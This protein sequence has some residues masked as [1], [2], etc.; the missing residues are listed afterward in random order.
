MSR[1][2]LHAACAAVLVAGSPLLANTI[3]I[4][5]NPI[6]G[7]SGVAGTDYYVYKVVGSNLTRDDAAP[8]STILQGSA[9]VAGNANPQG[10]V[11]LFANSET[12]TFAG[13]TF[14]G[15]F[16]SAP[17][18]TISGTLQ[19]VP[20][21]I[22]S[23]NGNDWFSKPGP[24]YDTT[25]AGAADNSTLA[26]KWF[27]DFFSFYNFDGVM[28]SAG[29]SGGTI[30]TERANLFGQFLAG[31]GFQR[32]SDPNIA[33][34][35]Q[36]DVTNVVS[37][38]YEGTQSYVKTFILGYISASPNLTTPQKAAIGATVNAMPIDLSE[39]ALVTYNG[40]AATPTYGFTS[41]LVGLTTD[42][43][44]ESYNSNFEMTFAG[45]P[46]PT[47]L[48]LLGLGGMALLRRSRKSRA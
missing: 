44:T 33:Y 1:S 41:S 10:N 32:V 31:N 18:V 38:G 23:L 27:N 30:A 5:A 8:M 46:E 19:G 28:S 39:V 14:G 37:I 43:L 9:P 13:T 26:R 7:P 22:S 3:S 47:S 4:T 24:V 17:H 15:A 2:I 45:V 35:N 40:G 20:I 29:V 25:Y 42:D 6:T 21:S 36:D 16:Y 48:G 11:E 34:V 12:S